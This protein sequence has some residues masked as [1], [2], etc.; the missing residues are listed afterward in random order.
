MQP[1]QKLAELVKRECSAGTG[2]SLGTGG[3]ATEERS[4]HKL[5]RFVPNR[6]KR[7]PRSLDGGQRMDDSIRPIAPEVSGIGPAT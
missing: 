4:S 7:P 5:R 6:K 1:H 3:T 2:G